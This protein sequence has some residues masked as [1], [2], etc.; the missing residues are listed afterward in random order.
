MSDLTPFLELHEIY[1]GY[2]EFDVLNGLSLR[3]FPGEIV[4]IIG[5]NGAGKST[6]LKAI[7]GL[8]KVRQGRITIQDKPIQALRPVDRLRH[9]LAFVPQGRSNFPY[10]TVRENLEMAGFTRPRQEV[11]GRLQQVFEAFPLLSQRANHRAGTLSGGQQQFL[12]M[13]MAMMLK[14]SI[15]MVDEPSLGLDP[16]NYE[17]VFS[18]IEEVHATGVAILMVEQNA[19]KALSISDRAYV[20]AQGRNMLDGPAHSLL[21]DPEVQTLY[22]GG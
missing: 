20:L 1:A 9:G 22:L 7:F 18:A 16:Y 11:E 12:E 6:V 5:P 3:V 13:A 2:T 8:V 21:D 19:V 10:M 17:A 4:S 14:P 15:I